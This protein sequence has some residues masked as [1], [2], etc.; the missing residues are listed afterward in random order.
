M[1]GAALAAAKRQCRHVDADGDGEQQLPFHELHLGKRDRRAFER[2]RPERDRLG[3][4]TGGTGLQR[5]RDGEHFV[6]ADAGH[7]VAAAADAPAAGDHLDA[8][9]AGDEEVLGSDAGP[10][11]QR[12]AV[13]VAGD[14]LHRHQ[15]GAIGIDRKVGGAGTG[16]PEFVA[17][18]AC[19]IQCRAGRAHIGDIDV[20]LGI[21]GGQ[22]DGGAVARAGQQGIGLRARRGGGRRRG[23]KG[24][25]LGRGGAVGAALVGPAR[26]EEADGDGH[27]RARHR[28]PEG[29][30]HQDRIQEGAVVGRI[31]R[32]GHGGVVDAQAVDRRA[33]GAADGDQELGAA[34]LHGGVVDA[35]AVRVLVGDG[36]IGQVVDADDRGRRRVG[37]VGGRRAQR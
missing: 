16:D 2:Q 29:V 1:A 9:I 12:I 32:L 3:G 17:V 10:G 37:E 22:A 5:S 8:D 27:A 20:A 6:A 31:G 23:V 34:V 11:G 33:V 4:R 35:D 7:R 14:V 21:E 26:I 19:D 15:R 25:A 18:D 24:E 30:G 13:G 28:G 36:Q